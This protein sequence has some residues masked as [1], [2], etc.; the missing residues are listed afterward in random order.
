[1]W[2]HATNRFEENEIEENAVEADD[3]GDDPKNGMA[4]RDGAT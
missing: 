4:A 1:V 3:A 2:F